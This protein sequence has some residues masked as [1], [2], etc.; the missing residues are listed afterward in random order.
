[1]GESRGGA[2]YLG[3]YQAT[4]GGLFG[5]AA[6]RLLEAA[7]PIS[8]AISESNVRD[9]GGPFTALKTRK[10]LLEP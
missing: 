8:F 6:W 1:M 4:T 9:S 3:R 5:A 10:P 7:S 2:E